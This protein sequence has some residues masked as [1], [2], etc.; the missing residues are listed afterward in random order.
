MT[1]DRFCRLSIRISFFL[2]IFITPWIRAQAQ[3]QTYGDILVEVERRHTQGVGTG[4]G[5]YRALVSNSSTTHS[6]HVAVVLIFSYFG[7]GR[8]KQLKREIELAPKSSATVSMFIP[9]LEYPNTTEVVI[10]GQRQQEQ[11]QVAS[12]EGTVDTGDRAFGLLLSP[13]IFKSGAL[14]NSNF[15]DG[16]KNPSGEKV[17]ATQAQEL[18]VTEWST[19]WLSFARYDGIV[20]SGEELN[21]AAEGIRTAMLRYVERGGALLVTGNW[22][23]PPQWQARQG[24][25]TQDEFKSEDDEDSE[26]IAA[27]AI[28]PTPA[29]SPQPSGS[30]GTVLTLQIT[31]PPFLPVASQAQSATDLRVHF[32]G[33]GTVTLTGAVAPSQ[34]T[35]NQWKWASRNFRESRPAEGRSY[36][37]VADLNRA[38]QVV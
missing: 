27:A 29:A 19:N 23:V 4:Y 10:D 17:V 15:E 16:F 36:Y 2:L 35:V 14:R 37:T 30:T 38:F 34:V 25:I 33:F 21:A 6:H 5:E 22:Q 1:A 12:K 11:L 7:P 3:T 31:K 20:I 9:L 26:E 28:P 18:P 24:F 8:V 32:I 13:Q